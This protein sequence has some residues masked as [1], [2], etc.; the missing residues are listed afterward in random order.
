MPAWLPEPGTLGV[1]VGGVALGIVLAMTVGR[2]WARR[3]LEWWAKAEGLTLV[4]FRGVPFWDSP[5]GWRRR[6]TD[7]DYTVVVLDRSGKRREGM[8]M[9][10]GPW[11]GFGPQDVE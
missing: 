2:W 5:R 3:R 7:D 11:H 10:T 4:E 1:L 9:F 8:V 6:D